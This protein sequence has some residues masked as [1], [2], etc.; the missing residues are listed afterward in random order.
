M[1][2]DWWRNDPMLTTSAAGAGRGEPPAAA[3]ASRS[4]RRAREA[5]RRKA[6]VAETRPATSSPSP[7]DSTRSSCGDVPG[8]RDATIQVLEH[9]DL[10]AVTCSVDL[11]EFGEEALR[12]QPREPALARGGGPRPRRRGAGD[13]ARRDHRP[14]APGHDLLGRGECP[15]TPRRVVRRAPD[16]TRPRGGLPRVERQGI[17]RPRTGRRRRVRPAATR[18][19][20]PT[21]H[22]NALGPTT[23]RPQRIRLRSW[24][25]PCTTSSGH[26]RVPCAGSR[27]RTRDSRTSRAP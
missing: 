15:S 1:G 3:S 14:H 23:S 4:W 21:S 20:P 22:G 18:R 26:G 27:R 25:T 16:R 11:A 17:R 8:L 7:A 10:Q 12:A 19:V 5:R 24:P 13:S 6:R 2:I 9:R